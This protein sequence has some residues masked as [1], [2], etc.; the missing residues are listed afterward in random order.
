MLRLQKHARPLTA[1]TVATV[2]ALVA[3]VPSIA[4]A[5]RSTPAAHAAAKK[6]KKKKKKQVPLIATVNGSFTIR[7]DAPG[8]FGYDDGPLWQQLKVVIKDAEIP[9]REPNR[10]SG[11]ASVSVRFEYEDEAHTMAYTGGGRLRQ[12][13]LPDVRLVVGHHA[14][15]HQRGVRAGDER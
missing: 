2:V 12:R 11:S 14:R 5:D 10:R 8:G 6:K 15:Y 3:F 9:F 13:G 4:S 7:R 1:I